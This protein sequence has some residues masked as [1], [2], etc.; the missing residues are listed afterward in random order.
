MDSTC[1]ETPYIL[2][3]N[4]IAI[5][6]QKNKKKKKTMK[7]EEREDEKTHLSYF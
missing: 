6:K 7:K 5:E 4:L 3:E 2:K 1:Y